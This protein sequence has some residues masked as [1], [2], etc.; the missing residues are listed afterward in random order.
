MGHINIVLLAF[1]FLL[2]EHPAATI[3]MLIALCPEWK[4]SVIHD[5]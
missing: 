2:I 5:E 4:P 3:V 1:R